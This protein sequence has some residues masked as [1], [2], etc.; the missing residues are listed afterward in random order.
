MAQS[1][2]MWPVKQ[3]DHKKSQVMGNPEVHTSISKRDTKPPVK[4]D[5]YTLSVYLV[6]VWICIVFTSV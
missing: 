6:N 4:F 1:N 2:H 3:S 5:I